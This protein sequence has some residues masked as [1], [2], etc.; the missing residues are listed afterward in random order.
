MI[1]FPKL[2]LDCAG[3]ASRG[4][5]VGALRGGEADRE[6]SCLSAARARSCP[7]RDDSARVIRPGVSLRC[8]SDGRKRSR[9]FCALRIRVEELINDM[10]KEFKGLSVVLTWV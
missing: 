4:G 3:G 8:S 5:D 6:D 9:K 2:L 7:R 1:F 10:T